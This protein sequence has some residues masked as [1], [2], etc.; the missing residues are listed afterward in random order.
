[1]QQSDLRMKNVFGPNPNNKHSCIKTIGLKLKYV[2]YG[3]TNHV[4]A[5]LICL[6]NIPFPDLI[7][8]QL[9]Y[10]LTASCFR[11]W[12][13]GLT[14]RKLPMLCTSSV[15]VYTKEAWKPVLHIAALT[16]GSVAYSSYHS[17]SFYK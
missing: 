8:Y 11:C 4:I 17:S 7:I 6:A 2:I 10:N 13:T 14:K 12:S 15:E 16:G 3:C 5:N 1:M 9:E